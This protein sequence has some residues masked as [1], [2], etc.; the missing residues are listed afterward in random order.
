MFADH[1]SGLVGNGHGV[2]GCDA[3]TTRRTVAIRICN[4]FAGDFDLVPAPAAGRPF[5]DLPSR[6]REGGRRMRFVD[7][8][9]TE[10]IAI[11]D[12][13]ARI[14]KRQPARCRQIEAKL[15]G[16]KFAVPV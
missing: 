13:V 3:G 8:S 7:V 1:D 10:V 12:E 5:E 11:A 2:V 4:D 14:V 16:L 6:P 9:R 15:G